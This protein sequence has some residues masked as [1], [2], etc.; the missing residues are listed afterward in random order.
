M[1]TRHVNLAGDVTTSPQFEIDA[2]DGK[3]KK[4]NK[5]RGLLKCNPVYAPY[6]VNFL[7]SP[8][9]AKTMA[10]DGI[11]AYVVGLAT[12]ESK[13]YVYRARIVDLSTWERI[14]AS[15]SCI[16]YSDTD[17]KLYVAQ[18][19]TLYVSTDHAATWSELKTFTTALTAQNILA[20]GNNIIV[21]FGNTTD[22]LVCFHSE[23]AGATWSSSVSFNGSIAYERCTS[24]C[25]ADNGNAVIFIMYLAG[26][27]KT[28]H[29]YST[30]NG[31]TWNIV[32]RT[33][34]YS[35]LGYGIE[36][37]A[38]GNLYLTSASP[39]TAAGRAIEKS[40]NNGVSFSVFFQT[41]NYTS[42]ADGF[43]PYKICFTENFAWML[44]GSAAGASDP[45]HIFI[46]YDNTTWQKI[47]TLPNQTC[48]GILGLPEDKLLYL[49]Y[50]PDEYQSVYLLSFD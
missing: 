35:N 43:G 30:D 8:N 48:V 37:D 36:K 42:S 20:N 2:T 47:L 12:A 16:A 26:R 27:Y 29:A 5:Y 15:A 50:T 19:Q 22:Q 39:S 18:N 13:Y 41:K 9:W 17:G 23:D 46:S 44:T 7:F 32:P 3:I 34:G 40:T 1:G 45:Q 49:S 4:I 10:H 11:W 31:A 21:F 24:V 38:S 6:N 25:W 33:D 28:A 14:E